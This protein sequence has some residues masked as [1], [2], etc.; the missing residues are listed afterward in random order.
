MIRRIALLCPSKYKC[1]QG[2]LQFRK[3][4]SFT[5]A[6]ASPQHFLLQQK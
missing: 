3:I 5:F 1:L 4:R 6:L 2:H